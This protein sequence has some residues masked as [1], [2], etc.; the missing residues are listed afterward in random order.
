MSI[1]SKL[2]DK[3]ETSPNDWTEIE[4]PSSGVGSESWWTN[5]RAGLEAYACDDQGYLTIQIHRV[6]DG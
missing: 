3:T 2:A 6:G 1:Q 4:G 5:D